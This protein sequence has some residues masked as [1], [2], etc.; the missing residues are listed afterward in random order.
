[1]REIPSI[2]EK[3]FTLLEILV[4]SLIF[5]VGM[6][7]VLTMFSSTTESNMAA[8]KIMEAST[9]ASEKIEELQNTPFS[10]LSQAGNGNDT[11][12]GMTRIYS[13]EST[14]IADLKTITVTVQWTT[15][16]GG[17]KSVTLKTARFRD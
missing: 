10:H 12:G 7:G 13:T 5:V 2:N 14:N 1:M 4:A 9:Y 17:T 6:M 11:I 8:R 3:G 16:A 15:R